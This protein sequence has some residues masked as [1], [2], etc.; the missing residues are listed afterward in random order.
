MLSP[1]R[2]VKSV[3]IL[4]CLLNLS[5]RAQ[6]SPGTIS[7]SGEAQVVVTPNKAVLTATIESQAA[8]VQEARKKNNEITNMILKFLT[9]Q[10]LDE[11]QIE[12]DFIEIS[13]VEEA[14][15]RY[16][17]KG[18]KGQQ[19]AQIN[20]LPAQSN[21]PFGGDERSLANEQTLTIIYRATRKLSITVLDLETLEEIYCGLL[22]NGITRSP[23]VALQ[24][25]DAKLHL[26]KVRQEAVQDA[27]DKAQL[28]AGQL[29]AN[30]VAIRSITESET[31]AGRLSSGGYRDPFDGDASSMPMGAGKL[32]FNAKVDIV[33]QLSETVLR[34]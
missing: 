17:E 13:V 25:T 31:G 16:Y 4:T 1:L 19:R 20:Q 28:M 22:T 18:Q 21:N 15:I 8:D 30:I 26:A 2:M 24:S 7:V 14:D 6:T 5:V 10:K 9:Q 33:F 27:K 23:T 11:Q 32:A 12:T 29:N 34:K 3:L